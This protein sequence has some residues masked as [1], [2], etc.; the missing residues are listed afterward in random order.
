MGYNIEDQTNTL[1][2]TEGNPK[3]ADAYRQPQKLVNKNYINV[4][5]C[6]KLDVSLDKKKPYLTLSLFTQSYK[7]LLAAGVR[8]A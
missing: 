8:E 4:L 3:P 7:W 1:E 6:D 2:D 5:T